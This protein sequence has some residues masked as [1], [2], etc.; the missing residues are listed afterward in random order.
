MT[1]HN[2]NNVPYAPPPPYNALPPGPPP[3][4]QVYYPSQP[5]SQALQPQPQPLQTQNDPLYP[6]VPP[7]FN[8][9]TVS[10]PSPSVLPGVQH[11]KGDSQVV[12]CPECHQAVETITYHHNGSAVVLSALALFAFGC[13]SGGCLIPFCCPLCK[14]VQHVCPNCDTT[15][16]TYSRLEQTALPGDRS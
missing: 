2:D 8:Y 13:H 6:Q 12:V 4:P 14:D 15:I 5:L 7:L 16:A 11:L 9:G 1:H 3:E 10:A